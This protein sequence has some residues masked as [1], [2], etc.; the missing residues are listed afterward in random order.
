MKNMKRALEEEYYKEREVFEQD[1]GNARRPI[2][3][4]GSAIAEGMRIERNTQEEEIFKMVKNKNLIYRRI[5]Y[6]LAKE[7]KK[8]EQPNI[9]YVPLFHTT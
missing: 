8:R 3:N 1:F 9:P 4:E 7:K 2:E 6:E 5:A